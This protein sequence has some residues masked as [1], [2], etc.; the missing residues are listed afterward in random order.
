MSDYGSNK[1]DDEKDDKCDDD[2]N[3]D[4][5]PVDWFAQS[6]L[7]CKEMGKNVGSRIQT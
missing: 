1:K 2:G 6:A 4:G 3:T 7:G 5:M